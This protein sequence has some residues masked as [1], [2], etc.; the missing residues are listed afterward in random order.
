MTNV[1]IIVFCMTALG[2]F[3]LPYNRSFFSL[4]MVG[5]FLPFTGPMCN[6]DWLYIGTRLQSAFQKYRRLFNWLM[7]LALAGCAIRLPI[8]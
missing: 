8:G 3:V 2:S 1:K 5:C 7:G 6:L 4:L